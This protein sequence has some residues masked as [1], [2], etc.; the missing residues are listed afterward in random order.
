MNLKDIKSFKLNRKKK[1]RVGRGRGS[2]HGKTCCRGSKGAKSRS[3]SEFGLL[4]EGGQMPLFRRIPKRGFNNIFK[5]EYNIIN[6][7]DL[8][9]FAENEL[10]DTHKLKEK[11]IIKKDKD[12]LKILGEGEIKKPLKIVA[13][14]FSK[15]AIK[16]IKEAGGEVSTK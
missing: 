15:G 14:K 9:I 4:F 12:G 11:G 5:K 7:K 3:G 6:V 16:K 10:V 1:K 8:D 2:G 13:H